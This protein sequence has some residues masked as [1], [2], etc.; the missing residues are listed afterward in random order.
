MKIE[1]K[2]TKK[3]DVY[4][5]INQVV[6]DGLQKKGLQWFKT[7]A[8]NDGPFNYATGRR[9]N[10]LNIFWLNCVCQSNGWEFNEWMTLK[11]A[12]KLGGKIAKG[13]ES[14]AVWYYQISYYH[15]PTQKW[16]NDL[17]LKKAKIKRSQCS[18]TN[19]TLRYFNVFNIDQVEGLEPK[20]LKETDIVTGEP[21]KDADALVKS[22]LA[23]NKP[24]KLTH[25]PGGA[26]FQLSSDK[27]N[28]PKAKDFIDHDSYHKTLFHEMAHSTGTKDRL[29]RATLLEVNKWGD[30]T[31]AKEELV[32]EIS[33]MYLS[34]FLGLN[35][36]DSDENSQAYLNGWV[37]N[38]KGKK[39]ELVS[40]MTQAAKVVEFIKK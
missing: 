35:P 6:L 14:T 33:A 26:Y 19:W 2:N 13:T 4:E 32:A 29:N 5:H 34:G 25:G 8:G 16:Y 24:L 1:V 20:G 22:Y 28:M 15:E 18:K 30:N 7:W 3:Y 10:G 9:Y 11:Q 31:Y 40:A 27:I 37:K 38:L 36:K 21:N 17:Q 12:A 23:A 39:K